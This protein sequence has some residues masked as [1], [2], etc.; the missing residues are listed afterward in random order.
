MTIEAHRIGMTLPL[1]CVAHYSLNPTASC[2]EHASPQ[3][4][5][6]STDP[7]TVMFEP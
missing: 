2:R 7:F 5:R 1:Q 4:V 6:F 3:Q